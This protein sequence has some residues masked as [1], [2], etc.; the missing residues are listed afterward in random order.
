VK[1]TGRKHD[2][3]WSAWA[4]SHQPQLN[5]R[6]IIAPIFC[7]AQAPFLG[8]Q[9]FPHV[10]ACSFLGLTGLRRLLP[11]VVDVENP[12]CIHW[13][14]G[15]RVARCLAGG[16]GP[17]AQSRYADEAVSSPQHLPE[18][19]AADEQAEM[20]PN[21]AHVSHLPVVTHLQLHT[22]VRLI[23]SSTQQLISVHC[24]GFAA[25]SP[26]QT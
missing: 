7:V 26:L 10:T 1:Q 13:H 4:H 23:C 9:S 15:R 25:C 21:V 12:D 14:T 8:W 24:Q 2:F 5:A 16:S 6:K 19:P 3:S 11:K 17:G 20:V 22:P 18:R